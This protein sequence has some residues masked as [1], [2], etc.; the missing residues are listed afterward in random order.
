MDGNNGGCCKRAKKD[1][2]QSM[3]SS[4]QH[5]N[6]DFTWMERILTVLRETWITYMFIFTNELR[7]EILKD[8]HVTNWT[9]PGQIRWTLFSGRQKDFFCQLCGVVQLF[10]LDSCIQNK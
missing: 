5:P 6:G 1:Q 9:S 3:Q 2:L 8:F 4:T 10:F 7:M